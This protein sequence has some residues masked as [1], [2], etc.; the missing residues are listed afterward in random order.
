MKRA[1]TRKCKSHPDGE[2]IAI[3]NNGTR[4][5]ICYEDSKKKRVEKNIQKS[6]KIHGGKYDYSLTWYDKVKDK[7]KIICPKHGVFK[8]CIWNHL[9]GRGCPHCAREEKTDNKTGVI[10]KFKEIHDEDY[11]YSL[12]E[13]VNDKVK[14]K[15]ICPKHGVFE[16]HPMKHK[17]GQGC[18]K[19][20]MSHGERKVKRFLD[21]NKV[22][23]E[24]Q[25]KFSECKNLNPL[26][27]D[28]YLP[29]FDVCIEYDGEQ[30]FE[31]RFTKSKKSLSNFEKTKNND[32]IKDDFCIDN[33]IGLLRIPYYDKDNIEIILE[34][35]ILEWEKR[36]K[37]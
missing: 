11:D 3:P 4:C 22:L 27:F 29:E 14:V 13:Y 16:Q 23:Y 32:S 35:E 9:K 18:P 25:K 36:R 19:C 15:I 2:R 1:R 30:H 33:N 21:K 28:F 24:S 17:T 34:Q 5:R 37:L 6:M 20:R 8:Q 31:P 26:P 7:A 12:V 10:T